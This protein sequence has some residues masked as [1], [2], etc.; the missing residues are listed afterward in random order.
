MC[1]E[2]L[3][4]GAVVVVAGG[5]INQNRSAR[6]KFNPAYRGTLPPTHSCGHVSQTHPPSTLPHC[7]IVR[8]PHGPHR[9][10]GTLPHGHIVIYTLCHTATL[11]MVTLLYCH[12]VICPFRH[13]VTLSHGHIVILPY[14]HISTLPHC[15]IPT[16]L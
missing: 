11:P 16:M 8:L 12:V 6:R 1:G 14:C 10:I 7:H 3:E 15:H 5:Y 4:V 9:Y 2:A 13:I